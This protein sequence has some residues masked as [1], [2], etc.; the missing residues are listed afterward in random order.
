MEILV[1][2]AGYVGLVTGAGL[3]SSGNHVVIADLD[4]NKINSLRN[5]EIPFYEPQLSDLV[6]RAR[7]RNNISFT[8]VGSPEYQKALQESEFYFIAVGTPEL[9]NGHADMRAVFSVVETL[10]KLKGDL[11]DKIVVVKSTVPVG[12]GDQIEEAFRKKRKNPKVVSNPE[13]LKQGNAVQ[14]FLKPERVII[15]TDDPGARAQLNFLYK[16]FMM[17]RERVVCMSRRSA[18]LV[19]Y[20]CNTFLATKISFINEMANLCETLG[21]DIREVRDGM[22]T[23][24]RI[25]DQFLFP[26]VGFGGS[27]FPKD[28]QSLIAQGKE[29]GLKLQ[30]PLATREVNQ[31]QKLWAFEKLKTALGDNL[32]KKKI[33]IWGLSFKPN[34]D[35]LRE[36]PSVTMIEK[37]I[38]SKATI[39]A[40]DPVAM[41]H[42]R[43]V[44]KGLIS[45][46]NLKLFEDAYDCLQGCDALV[47][48]T[49]WQEFRTP[50]FKKIKASLRNAL[51][52]DGR[53]I[54]DPEIMSQYGFDYYRVGMGRA[55]ADVAKKKLRMR[56][57]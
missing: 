25:G 14:D 21:A 40:Y 47:I 16:P 17:K 38:G 10:S 1:F 54:Y 4:Q 51:I 41:P 35:D 55:G 12:T 19:K 48:M 53:N 46:G 36:A 23:D 8:T 43:N 56:A 27:C 3:A 45:Q 44:L 22:I 30:L 39:Q 18:E 2:G 5:G 13:F 33:A 9:P 29:A 32:A 42:T 34:T 31:S 52:I 11:S 20:A 6:G 28:V 49:E 26:G 50:N 7:K 37:L 15:G 57:V 24:S